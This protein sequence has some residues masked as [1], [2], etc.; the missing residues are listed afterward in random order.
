MTRAASTIGM[1][2]GACQYRAFVQWNC[3]VETSGALYNSVKYQANFYKGQTPWLLPPPSQLKKKSKTFVVVRNPYSRAIDFYRHMYDE[4]HKQAATIV[5]ASLKTFQK[6]VNIST[7]HSPATTD[8]LVGRE[9]P[10][11]LNTFL[12]NVI[13]SRHRPHREDPLHL[14]LQVLYAEKVDHVVKYESWFSDLQTL[15]ATYNLT[16][17]LHELAQ[18][19]QQPKDVPWLQV[20]D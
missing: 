11:M 20:S 1:A 4:Q 12:Q 9:D 8:Y 13:V 5:L 6:N 14:P 3:P 18:P 2:W 15:L 7:S 10:V 19:E 17:M 16:Q